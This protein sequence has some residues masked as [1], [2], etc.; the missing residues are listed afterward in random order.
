MECSAKSNTNVREMFKAFLSLARIPVT[1]SDDCSLRRRSSAHASVS[2]SRTPTPNTLSPV[3]PLHHTEGGSA[4]FGNHQGDNDHHDGTTTLSNHIS[5]NASRLKPRS[6]SLIRRTSK[7]VNKVKDPNAD[8]EDC[9]VSWGVE[10]SSRTQSEIVNQTI[11]KLE[12]KIQIIFTKKQSHCQTFT[13]LT[14]LDIISLFSRSTEIKISF[15]LS[16]TPSSHWK[17]NIYFMDIR[18]SSS[19]VLHRITASSSIKNDS[20]SV[21]KQ[22]SS[23]SQNK[24]KSLVLSHEPLIQV[25][26]YVTVR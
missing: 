16:K 21:A 3:V 24:L 23:E 8:P 19:K 11:S 20:E 22:A 26:S 17:R 18:V 4:F 14:S 13:L 10:T 9:I 1:P 5:I 12:R 25:P 15:L 6:R 7:K 2:K